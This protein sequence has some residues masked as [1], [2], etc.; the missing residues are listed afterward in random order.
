MM[1]RAKFKLGEINERYKFIKI[2]TLYKWFGFYLTTLDNSPVVRVEG[3]CKWCFMCNEGCSPTWCERRQIVSL[4]CRVIFGQ[5]SGDDVCE[6]VQQG[7]GGLQLEWV[8]KNDLDTMINEYDSKLLHCTFVETSQ[9]RLSIQVQVLDKLYCKVLKKIGKYEPEE[10]FM[11][12]L[13]ANGSMAPDGRNWK[14]HAAETYFMAPR[15]RDMLC[16]KCGC[17]NKDHDNCIGEKTIL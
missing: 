13:G 14:E 17:I 7:L 16:K 2:D 12:S 3:V 6:I 8:V 1:D 11:K 15:G 5:M 10:W 9:Y 4:A